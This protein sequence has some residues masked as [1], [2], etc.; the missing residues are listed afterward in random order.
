MHTLCGC[1][2]KYPSA[3]FNTCSETASTVVVDSAVEILAV[4]KVTD[5]MILFDERALFD[6]IAPQIEKRLINCTV[7]NFCDVLHVAG[8]CNNFMKC[9]MGIFFD[10]PFQELAINENHEP[11]TG[12]WRLP[13]Q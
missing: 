9:L 5:D 13:L 1:G 8:Y 3:K 12:N 11:S 10:I 6:A 7:V 4:D 2:I